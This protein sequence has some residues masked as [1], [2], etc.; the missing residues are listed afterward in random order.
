MRRIVIIAAALSLAAAVIYLALK[1]FSADRGNTPNTAWLQGHAVGGL[2]NLVPAAGGKILPDRPFHD[3][4]GKPLSFA[5]F[6]GK[7]VVINFWAT[8]CAPCREEMPS[9][10]RLAAATKDKPIA[11]IAISIDRGGVAT[12]KPFLDDIG[13]KF[14]T[15]YTDPGGPLSRELGIFGLPVTLIVDHN[16]YELARHS[17]PAA[18]DEPQ[19]LILLNA[20]LKASPPK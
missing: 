13:V 15:A 1:D 4:P 8:W 2:A 9:L 10:D 19:V 17:G 11:V 18:W 5:E 20:A 7:V 14:L 3:P 12:A 6:K 16:G